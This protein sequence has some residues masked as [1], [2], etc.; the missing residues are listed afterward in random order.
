MYNRVYY[1]LLLV[2][3]LTY[4]SISNLIPIFQ[5]DESR[6]G[7]NALEMLQSKNFI[8]TTYE[9]YADNW[10][11][12]PPLA[13]WLMSLTL[14]IFG[15]TELA[16]RLPAIIFATLTLLFSFI[17]IKKENT[18]S[19]LLGMIF[20]VSLFSS[21]GYSGYHVAITAD[22]DSILVFFYTIFCLSVFY[23]LEYIEI[24]KQKFNIYLIVSVIAFTLGFLTKSIVI[25]FCMPAIIVYILIYHNL[26]TFLKKINYKT[27]LFIFSSISIILAYYLI[28][29]SLSPGY[30]QAVIN[31]E[32]TGR[33]KD[34]VENH[35]EPFYFYLENIF[36]GR[37]S[38]WIYFVLLS[39]IVY[40]KKYNRDSRLKRLSTF[41]L[42]NIVLFLFIISSAK[43]KLQWYDAAIYPLIAIQI[44]IV[45]TVLFN[46]INSKKI[47]LYFNVILLLLSFYSLFD[48]SNYY[49]NLL[50]LE[51]WPHE[52]NSAL[53][54][55]TMDGKY[56][57]PIVILEE[58]Y[59]SHLDC[60]LLLYNNDSILVQKSN[61]AQ[62]NIN[63]SKTYIT[64][65]PVIFDVIAKF[66]IINVLDISKL[67]YRFK[68]Q[69]FN[70]LAI[71]EYINS[72]KPK[73]INNKVWMD[74]IYKKSK[75]NNVSIEQ[76]IILDIIYISEIS[77]KFIN[78]SLKEYILAKYY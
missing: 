60:Y 67:G 33:Y 28:R 61:Y 57:K 72:E 5:W 76:Q 69:G 21:V 24:D 10:N 36:T 35:I 14:T 75:Q 71:S 44:L 73:I 54:K 8:V 11:S 17:L 2:L 19:P 31:N 29:N 41:L 34:G 1:F 43:T 50:K 39:P 51:G 68:I 7:V 70:S 64:S 58:G 78:N 23:A 32:I 42:I 25:G 49:K 63:S 48:L 59:Q 12:K 47:K 37:F 45:L 15:K 13:I 6:L 53:L 74:D 46:N 66:Y 55:Y 38:I 40:L 52:K 77:N 3:F 4:I 22:Y 62:L 56:D 9:G 26:Y 18:I 16:L 27:Y 20:F 30:I 65:N